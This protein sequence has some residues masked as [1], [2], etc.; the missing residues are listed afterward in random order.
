MLSRDVRF[1]SRITLTFPRE[2]LRSVKLS[3]YTS[4][5]ESLAAHRDV[6]K[7]REHTLEEVRKTFIRNGGNVVQARRTDDK[8]HGKLSA[9]QT[10]EPE[11]KDDA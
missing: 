1:R 2:T 6:L 7:G 11:T 10:H 3:L 8:G 9:T 4:F 5:S